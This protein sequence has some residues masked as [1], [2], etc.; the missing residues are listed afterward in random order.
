MLYRLLVTQPQTF[1]LVVAMLCGPIALLLLLATA[2]RSAMRPR[3]AWEPPN[4]GQCGTPLEIAS[5]NI[6]HVC[7]QC[8]A[9]LDRLEHLRF[10]RS[11]DRDYRALRWIGVAVALPVLGLATMAFCFPQGRTYASVSTA[12]LIAKHLDANTPWGW[13]ELQHRAARGSLTSEHIDALLGAYTS[14]FEDQ[15][16]SKSHLHVPWGRNLLGHPKILEFASDEALTE[17]A[18]AVY[19]PVLDFDSKYSRPNIVGVA[20]RV[21]GVGCFM[22]FPCEVCWEVVGFT[23]DGEPVN[24]T[25]PETSQ[26]TRPG[27]HAMALDRLGEV[28]RVEVRVAAFRGSQKIDGFNALPRFSRAL[29]PKEEAL[30]HWTLTAELKSPEK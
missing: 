14:I 24:Y 23:V 10:D 29:D 3:G 12:R 1:Q 20:L 16:A 30:R 28:V 19:R 21:P 8:G 26:A 13:R 7:L 18:S 17:L 5:A 4:C 6:S 22:T 27:G 11:P 25:D 15:R 9:E 2:M